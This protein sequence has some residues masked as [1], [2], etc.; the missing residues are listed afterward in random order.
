MILL[1]A[2]LYDF[3]LEQPGIGGNEDSTEGGLFSGSDYCCFRYDWID[4][5]GRSNYLCKTQRTD[6]QARIL[7]HLSSRQH[8]TR[9]LILVF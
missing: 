3:N 4:G 8:S 7:A 9:W 1:F 5:T 2:S 6:M